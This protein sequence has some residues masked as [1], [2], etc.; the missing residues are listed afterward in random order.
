MD[1]TTLDPIAHGLMFERFLNPS[2][3]SLPDIDVDVCKERRGEVIEYLSDKYGR[4]SVAQIATFNRLKAKGT[5]RAVGRA[6]DVPIEI[7]EDLSNVLPKDAGE[8]SVSLKEIMDGASHAPSQAVSKFRS[9]SAHTTANKAYIDTAL[10]LEGTYKSTGTHAGA[11]V[12]GNE[13]LI[14]ILPLKRAEGGGM[15]TQFSMDDVEDL[16]LLKM[17]LL[18]L[19]TLTMISDALFR[20]RQDNPDGPLKGK[21]NVKTVRNLQREFP[22][23]N[24]EKVYRT[25]FNNG[26][27]IGIFQCD[28]SGIRELLAKIKCS[29]FN[30]ISAVLALYRPGPLDAGM[31]G[32]FI[33]RRRTREEETLWHQDLKEDLSGTHGHAIYQEQIMQ[34]ARTLCDF[35]LSKADNLRKVIGKKKKD[36]IAAFRAEFLQGAK[37]SG[38]INEKEADKIYD[39]IELFGRYAFCKGHSVS[40]ACITYYAGWLKTYYPAYFCAA[41]LNKFVA[42]SIVSSGVQKNIKKSEDERLR[43]YLMETQALGI[44]VEAPDIASSYLDFR[45]TSSTSISFGLGS[46]KSVGVRVQALTDLRDKEGEFTS[47]PNFVK[48]CIDVGINKGVAMQFVEAGCI[49]FGIPKTELVKLIDGTQRP[50]KIG[51]GL[52]K[53]KKTIFD[54]IRDFIKKR[55]KT[56]KKF[57]KMTQKE[58]QDDIETRLT[59]YDAAVAS[60]CTGLPVKASREFSVLNAPDAYITKTKVILDNAKDVT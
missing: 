18:G 40:Y 47:F 39:D 7:Q 21:K 45:P 48:A 38:K 22:E 52:T 42:T 60:L 15:V 6:L 33:D 30:D 25:V 13:P 54:D 8:F 28:S 29:S 9:F 32:S 2:R 11:V 1:I 49:D 51:E 41:V 10:G 5:I 57:E 35:D 50:K 17:D 19:D 59:N 56:G 12:I 55:D 31:T 3:V 20:I 27:T 44:R 53:I 34:T 36:A 4:E 16:G 14:N 46:L 26:R 23:F 37:I 43:T 24:D 58:K